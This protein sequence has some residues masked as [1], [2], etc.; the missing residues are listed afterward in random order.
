[1]EDFVHSF[2]TVAI[3]Q[4]AAVSLKTLKRAGFNLTK[5]V[6][7]EQTAI[8]NVNDGDENSKVCHRILGVQ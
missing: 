8:D 3:A 4:E 2:E 7:N 5:F 1:M 6:S